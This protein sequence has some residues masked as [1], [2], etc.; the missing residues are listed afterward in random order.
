ME[1][2]Y[3]LRTQDANPSHSKSESRRSLL[4]LHSYYGKAGNEEP[5]IVCSGLRFAAHDGAI[6]I[7]CAWLTRIDSAVWC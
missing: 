1:Q 6:D 3:G 5:K 7:C 2:S 4:Y